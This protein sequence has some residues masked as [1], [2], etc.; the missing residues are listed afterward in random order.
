MGC[1]GCGGGEGEARDKLSIAAVLLLPKLV[2]LLLVL[3][4]G[5]SDEV[6]KTRGASS[7]NAKQ[8]SRSVATLEGGR[9]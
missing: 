3:A 1:M 5:V 8:A 7:P 4:N 2:P 6:R 9:V